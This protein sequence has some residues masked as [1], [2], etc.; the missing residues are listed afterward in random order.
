MYIKPLRE[1]DPPF[2]SQQKL[3]QFIHDVFHNYRELHEHHAKLL[4]KFYQTQL[5][6]H[7]NIR[8]ITA[9]VFDM[10]LNSR[11]AYM[12]YVANCPI[13]VYRID[14]EMANNAAFKAFVEVRGKIMTCRMLPIY[15][16]ELH[17]S[18]RRTPTQY[19]KLHQQFHT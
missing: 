7:P 19:E 8:S 9:A 6:Q 12:E 4:D 14:D 17:S 1:A 2:I 15:L 5:E 11:E 3:K 16:A 13:A 18:S 10:V